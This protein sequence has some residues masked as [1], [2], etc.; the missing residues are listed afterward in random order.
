[1]KDTKKAPQRY[2]RSKKHNNKNV[3]P[4]EEERNKDINDEDLV[5]GDR[6]RFRLIARQLSDSESSEEKY[7]R[8]NAGQGEKP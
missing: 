5:A 2:K 1:M 8:Q 7:T 4:Q 3:V 6:P